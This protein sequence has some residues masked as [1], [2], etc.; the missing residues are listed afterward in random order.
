MT[1]TDKRQAILDA[2]LELIAQRGLHDTPVSLIVKQSGVSTGIVY[3]YFANKED[4]IDALF[5][6]V[7]LRLGQH[8]LAN[9]DREADWKTRWKQI[10]HNTFTFYAAHS[11][12]T[13]FLEQYE[14]SPHYQAYLQKPPEGEWLVLLEMAQ[15]DVQD[16]VVKALPLEAV[17]AMTI[18]VAVLLAKQQVV[19]RLTLSRDTLDS[20]A[21]ACCEAVRA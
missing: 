6:E 18:G 20:I 11:K 4:V 9:V 13:L 16:G 21:D 14:N 19:G 2:A 8:M 7:K 10:W 1:E 17:L 5:M 3:H 15:R 12:E